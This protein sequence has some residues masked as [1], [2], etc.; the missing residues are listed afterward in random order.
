M[1]CNTTAGSSTDIW[2][3]VWKKKGG[4]KVN[5]EVMCFIFHFLLKAKCEHADMYNRAATDNYF[6]NQLIWRLFK[7]LI[8]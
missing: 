3:S 1:V 7:R 2:L 4:E 5:C 8:G 6:H